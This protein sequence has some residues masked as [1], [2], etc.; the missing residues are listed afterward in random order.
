MIKTIIFTAVLFIV[1]SVAVAQNKQTDSLVQQLSVVKS[2][3]SRV[4]LLA[5]L[6]SDFRYSN[7]DSSIFYGQM[8]LSLARKIN[9][10]RGEAN[11]LNRL[12]VTFLSMGNLPKTMEL[13]YSALKISEDNNFQFEKAAC[14]RRIGMVY[15]ELENYSKAIGFFHVALKIDSA[16][17]NRG[18][19]AIA[20]ANLGM[21]YQY[22]NN[23]DS[24]LYYNQKAFAA[25]HDYKPMEAE[26]YRVRGDIEAMNGN[27][28]AALNYYQQGIQVGLNSNDSRNNSFTFSRLAALYKEVGEA[29][30]SIY[31]AL[32]GVE[33]GKRSSFK[34]GIFLSS[35]LLAAL[36]ESDNPSKS[37]YYY[38]I[39]VAAKDSLFGAGNIQAIQELIAKDEARKKEIELAKANFQSKLKQYGLLGGLGVVCIIAFILYRNN[40]QKQKDNKV[41]QTTF[42]NLKSTQAQL[43]QSEKMASLGELTAGIAHEIQNPLNFVNNFSEVNQDLLA[44]MKDQLQKENYED[45]KEMIDDL[46][47]N[48]EKINHHGKRADAIVK[49]MLQHSRRSSGVKAPTDINA[50]CDEYLRLSYHGLSAKDK[51]FNAT[52]KTDFDNTIGSI[53]IIPQDIG[54]VI[55]NLIMNAFYAVNEKKQ[56][57]GEDFEPTVTITTRKPGHLTGGWEA[58]ISVS[59]NGNGIPEAIKEKIFQP[60]FTTKPT[61]QGTGLGLSLAYDIVKAHGG[62]LLVISNKGNGS[63]FIIQLP[64][65]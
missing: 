10:L 59:D 39:A 48:E 56:H 50:L 58:E 9:F 25:L 17:K 52:L 24:A 14:L 54:R 1:S 21:L 11:T 27:K 43:I 61:G 46:I 45:A 15:T 3:S 30:S 31:Y 44:E 2:D 18:G 33:S 26:I 47:G 12:S 20:Y 57:V 34:K 7:T 19:V 40:R 37:L 6:C 8:A 13:Q 38:K 65:N 4:W 62:D 49:G 5:E 16:I 64:G 32:K 22:M 29:D 53:N 36:Y 63:E 23:A 35:N 41:L 51:S 55:L 28:D 42:D 60:F